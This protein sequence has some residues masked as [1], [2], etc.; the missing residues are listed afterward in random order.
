[1]FFI[2]MRVRTPSKVSLQ[3]CANGAPSTVTSSRVSAWL[4]GQVESYSR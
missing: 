1:M 4:R 3:S 2:R